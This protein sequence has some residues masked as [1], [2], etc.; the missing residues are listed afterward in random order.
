MPLFSQFSLMRV[1]LL[2]TMVGLMIPAHHQAASR[3]FEAKA[4]AVAWNPNGTLLAVG[5]VAG[6]QLYT[7]DWTL[8]TTLA[9]EGDELWSLAWSP[10]GTRL[11]GIIWREGGTQLE[12]RLYI[13]IW[14]IETTEPL[15]FDALWSTTISWSPGG[16]FIAGASMMSGRVHVWET[17][18]ANLLHEFLAPPDPEAGYPIDYA[19]FVC[20]ALLDDGIETQL[21][22]LHRYGGVM[23]WKI[24]EED[25]EYPNNVALFDS[26]CSLDGVSIVETSGRI[27]SLRDNKFVSEFPIIDQGTE[28]PIR[29]QGFVAAKWSPNGNFI[30]TDASTEN[31]HKIQI[32]DVTTKKLITTLEGGISPD[33]GW[34]YRD[35][36]S[37]HPDGH[38]LVTL[39]QDGLV[40]VWDTA[41]FELVTEFTY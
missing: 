39:S 18:T 2:V 23:A 28:S 36:L 29:F 33:I 13:Y 37:W 9:F 19:Q 14:D 27:I 16:R 30:A 4:T 11:G 1:V 6:V 15:V 40:R 8:V 34:P 31:N 17:S 41:T 24:E 32:W 26:P 21:Y 35:T 5:G 3:W 12:S 20:W 10:D 22:S 38:L 25:A 7:E